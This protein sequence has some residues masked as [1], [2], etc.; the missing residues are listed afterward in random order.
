MSFAV[1]FDIEKSLGDGTYLNGSEGIEEEMQISQYG[2][3][4]LNI[5]SKQGRSVHQCIDKVKVLE[6]KLLVQRL[7]L[8]LVVCTEE[9]CHPLPYSCNQRDQR[10]FMLLCHYLHDR[11]DI[12]MAVSV[13]TLFFYVMKCPEAL[14]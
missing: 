12:F 13:V 1:W 10:D 7:Q 4:S 9:K 14:L 8:S 2:A 5:A 11:C 6:K 3:D